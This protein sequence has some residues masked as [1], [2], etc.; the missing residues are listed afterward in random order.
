[1]AVPGARA[2]GWI[3]EYARA[4]ADGGV[5]AY[6]PEKVEAAV[7]SAALVIFAGTIRWVVRTYEA[8]RRPRVR[9]LIE[10][11]L[12]HGTSVAAGLVSDAR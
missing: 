3:A 1:V 7:A 5:A 11:S 8:E 12:R 4:L 2:A 9:A 6:G 10:T